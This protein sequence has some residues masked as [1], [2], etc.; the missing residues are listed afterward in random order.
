MAVVTRQPPI[1]VLDRPTGVIDRLDGAFMVLRQRARVIVAIAAVVVVPSSVVQAWAMRDDLGGLSFLDMMDDPA[2]AEEASQP[3]SV[4]DAGF[5]VGQVLGLLVTA[6]AGVAIGRVV[7]GWH[8]GRDIGTGEA[9][10]FT[11]RRSGT[12][13]AAFALSHLAELVGLVLVLPGLVLI[14]LF[15]LTSPV[16]A[17][18]RLGPIAAL[19]RSASLVRRRIGSVVGVMVLVGLVSYAVSEA[20]GTLPSAVA[21]VLGLHRTW[22]VLAVA[23][24]VASIITVTVTVAAMSLTYYDIRF[25]T[26]GLDLRRRLDEEWDG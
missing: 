17:A 16:L 21:L 1:P 10:V 9:L 15:S 5:F 23:N 26:E 2:L 8:E 7:A 22:P 4:Y 25:R 13:L 19:R 3:G 11:A 14:V 18:E 12:I 20:V 6:V 24:L